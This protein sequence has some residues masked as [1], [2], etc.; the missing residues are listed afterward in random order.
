MHH[1]PNDKYINI[2]GLS[3]RYHDE[4]SGPAV[5]MIHGMFASL[6][7]FQDWTHALKEN[8]RAISFD[9]PGFGFS[10]APNG[11]LSMQWYCDFVDLFL[12]ELY[13]TDV[14]LCGNSLGG[15]IAWEYT[16][17]YPGKVKKLVLLAPAGFIDKWNMPI[18]VYFAKSGL[19]KLFSRLIT[20]KTIHIALKTVYAN[21]KL[22]KNE[23]I[24]HYYSIVKRKENI[25]HISRLAQV[26]PTDNTQKLTEIKKPVLLIWGEKDRWISI[27]HLAKFKSKSPHAK[28]LTSKNWGHAPMEEAAEETLNHLAQFLN[29]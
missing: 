5:V 14:V 10:D 23:S 3:I 1:H 29:S 20:K 9:L 7:S 12:K 22:I 26:H 27:K 25:A 8:Y 17:R 11:K 2:N 21:K 24:D 16:W 28:V 18:P 19:L 6:Y 15:W 13:L 4:G